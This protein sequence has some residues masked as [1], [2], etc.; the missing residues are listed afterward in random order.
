MMRSETR[1][2]W[3]GFLGV[4]IFAAT[5]PMTRLAT[6]DAS[7]P[8]L[9][10]W[11][12]A[13]GRAFVAG[14][15]SIIF[16]AA[17]RSPWPKG[18][19]QWT[20]LSLAVVGNVIGWPLFLGLAMRQVS[21][22][23]AAVITALAPLATAIVVACI[24][25]LRARP[26]F[27][28][29][30]FLGAALTMGFSMLR[31]Y[32]QGHGFALETADLY[33]IAAIIF[34]AIGYAYGA[35][36]TPALGAEQTICW[37]CILG[38]PITIPGTL[39]SWPQ[40]PIDTSAWIGFAYTGIFSMWAGFFAWYRGLHLGGPLRVSQLQ[41]FQPFL[42]ILIAIPLLGEAFDPTA[43]VFAAAV[44]MVVMIGKRHAIPK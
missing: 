7:N 44:V 9:S 14:M 37:I 15:L 27:W 13:F 32:Q 24:L 17:V 26:L 22:T 5:V 23:H 4:A 42:S 34:A 16:L 28:V 29:C 3:L 2:L 21:A 43:L 30:A 1:G 18:R 39:M 19:M 38:L 36:V 35:R 31:A 25:K 20:S 6:G 41:L 33:L 10:P 12:I 8:Q 40:A 11:F